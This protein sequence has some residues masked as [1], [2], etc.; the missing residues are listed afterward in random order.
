MFACIFSVVNKKSFEKKGLSLSIPVFMCVSADEL[1]EGSGWW[2]CCCVCVTNH[3][4]TELQR[5]PYFKSLW[6]CQGLFWAGI[7]KE[8]MG[9]RNRGRR[10]LSYRPAR[11]HRL[12]E[13]IPWNRFRGPIHVSKYGSW[14]VHSMH[15]MR[16]ITT[17][18]VVFALYSRKESTV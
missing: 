5:W 2:E 16:I 11:L 12:A 14:K 4:V 1:G 10:G 13:F 9:A 17:N 8:A 3:G 15:G 6:Y 7:F 18:N